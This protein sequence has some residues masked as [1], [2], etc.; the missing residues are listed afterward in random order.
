MMEDVAAFI[1][2]LGID[3]PILYGFSDGGIIGILLAIKYPALVSKL[4][5]S[6]AN[7]RPDGI[8]GTIALMI[9]AAYFFTRKQKYK[10]MLTQ[11][12][13]TDAELN[14]IAA[15]TLVIAGSKDMIKDEHTKNIARNIPG[16]AIKILDGESH[17]SYVIHSDK[18]Y[19]IIDSY[20]YEGAKQ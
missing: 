9:K 13:I 20:E 18:L 1:R 2:E 8:K 14:T 19:D 4:I 11:P 10:L 7:T 15:P 17:A 16:S 6:G 12:N 5:V 3:S